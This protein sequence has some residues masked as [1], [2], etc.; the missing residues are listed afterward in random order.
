MV[1]PLLLLSR[2]VLPWPPAYAAGG[3][4]G[5][6]VIWGDSHD[7]GGP[8]HVWLDTTGGD[9]WPLDDDGLAPI[10]LPFPFTW[11]G[12]EYTQATISANGVLYFANATA[13][14]EGA[15]PSDGTLT[16]IAAY[17]DDL[18]A[19]TVHT[20]TFGV[21]PSRTFVVSWD[22]VRPKSAPGSGRVEVW[23]LEGRAEVVVVLDD[24]TFGDAAADGGVGAV[25]GVGGGVAGTG[26]ACAGGVGDGT[27]V[28]FGDQSTRPGRPVVHSDELEEPLFGTGEFLYAGRALATGDN[29]G[30]GADD[31][32]VGEPDNGSGVAYLLY[33]PYTPMGLD[34]ATTRF[35]G[36]LSGDAFGLAMAMSDLDN[37]GAAE[38][39]V[40]AP[41]SDG[42]GPA[43]GAVYT[44]SGGDR[45]GSFVGAD[46][47]WIA[48][49]PTAGRPAAG[50]SIVADADVD[51]D[52]YR[53]V[54]I[55]APTDDEG[56]VDGGSVLLLTGAATLTGTFLL[57]TP[58]A[59]FT[60]EAANERFGTALT[61]G[62]L[63]GDGRA[64][65][66]VA[67]P[68]SDAGA[69]DGGRVAVIPGGTWSG[70]SGETAVATCHWTDGV[71]GD[72]F[73]QALVVGDFDGSGF[74]DLAV[75]APNGDGTTTNVGFV[76][77][78][79][80][81]GLSGCAG[82]LTIADATVQGPSA[83]AYFGSALAV[84]DLDGDGVD[85]LLVSAP[86]AGSGAT[87]GGA[88]FGFAAPSGSLTTA[89][90][91]RQ[92]RGD[93]TAG[94][95]G[96]SLVVAHDA[97]SARDT[98][99]AGAPYASYAASS[100]GTVHAWRYLPDFLDE[101][102]DGFV[103]A[104]AGGND[105]DDQDPSAF[106]D[107]MDADDDGIDGD[108]DGWVDGVIAPREEADGWAWDLAWIGGG[109]TERYDFE[110]LA[111]DTTLSTYA[112]LSFPDLLYVTDDVYGTPSND[113]RAG[114]V[115]DSLGATMT[116]EFAEAID[117]VA[118]R[119]L[120]PEG[121]YDL[122][123]LD[124]GGAVVATYTFAADAD[125]TQGGVFEGWTFI[126][127]VHSLILTGPAGEGFGVDDIDVAWSHSSDRDGDGSTELAGDCDDDDPA[128]H[129]G[130][131]ELLDNGIDDD[132]DGIIDAGNVGVVLDPEG[133]AVVNGIVP[134]VIDFEAI[135]LGEVVDT[136]YLSLGSA[137]AGGLEGASSVG[138]AAPRGAVVARADG[139]SAVIYFR[140]NQTSVG[141]WIVGGDGDFIVDGL[142]HGDDRYVAIIQPDHTP[143]FVGLDFD[144]A[145]DELHVTP[146]DGGEV[147]GL[148]DVT[149]AL[150]GLDDADGDGT[151]EREGD[152]DDEDPTVYAGAEDEW[153]DGVDADCAG[154]NDD[155]QDG[156]GFPV[157]FDC[158]DG[159]ADVNPDAAE[160]YH[161]SIDAD[162]SG[163]SD[164]DVDGDGHDD[165]DWGGDDCDD[166][167]GEV[168]P[169][170]TEI[171][172]DGVDGDCGGDDDYDADQD[173]F[174]FNPAGGDD[175]DDA[176]ADVNPDASEVWYDGIDSDCS[177]DA[178]SD[179]DADGD[180]HIATGWGGNDCDDF[181]ATAYPDAPGERCY[182]NVDTNCDYGDDYDCDGDGYTY[183]AY[184]GEDCNDADTTIHPGVTDP[185]GDG[186]DANCDGGAEF[187]YDGDGY[188][189]IAD[190]G[191]DCDDEDGAIAPGV[192]DLCYDGIDSDCDA[193][194]DD[195]C[196]GDGWADAGHGGT[197]C[198]DLDP[199]VSPGAWDYLYDGLD[200]NCD[201][202]DDF[203]GDH[204]GQQVDWY[205][206]T[207]CDDV[208]ATVYVGAPDACYD[209]VDADC[210][211]DDD[212][213]C[214]HDSYVDLAAGGDDCDDATADVHPGATDAPDD[215]L[216]ADCD[217]VDPHVCH[218][219]D[220]DGH[221]AV[222]WGG[223]DCDDTNAAAYPGAP[224]VWYDNVDEDCVPADDFD[225]D[226]DGYAASAWGGVDC[227][228]ANPAVSP[229]VL[230]DDCGGT[231]DNCDGAVD[232][233]CEDVGD[234][235]ED[236]GDTGDSGGD[237]G[238]SGGDSAPDSGDTGDADRPPA[239]EVVTPDVKV[240]ETGGCAC[241]TGPRGGG[242]VAALG[243]VAFGL[244][245]FLVRRRRAS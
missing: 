41:G 42:N 210:A 74:L 109:E 91:D 39:L 52:G 96:T 118:L 180:G 20:R 209:G 218:D 141:F 48:R 134:Q 177:G 204:D 132:C 30:D 64:E 112:S 203:D 153:Y 227:D 35:T 208:D 7:A 19:S 202:A 181:V 171:W 107:G 122:V 104:A 37:D 217:G 163:G 197:D 29:D 59:T 13:E 230:V 158:D 18:A 130:A 116:I 170:A 172:Y 155:D 239:D 190:G 83:A 157:V 206:G 185:R 22:D 85:E 84:G 24:L 53:D 21:Y 25:I 15:C 10:D 60:G 136:Q 36:E 31:L 233:D 99:L 245:S 129:A 105:C 69:T 12:S 95:L 184:G 236:T 68:L 120:D 220:G 229:G 131:S 34:D 49:G 222:D 152:C 189:A 225:Q 211:A 186:I 9:A 115:Y 38:I 182:D 50:S 111:L 121:G 33:R 137:F 183:D 207:D 100:D 62:D 196:D 11:Y 235:A 205:G 156:D 174:P 161:D 238:D 231:D 213:D 72:H 215:G 243:G 92:L 216:D 178:L 140:E 160:V 103:S 169:D 40:G 143:F 79:T 144:V 26:Y 55:G 78:V 195:D 54:L 110:A 45:V 89:A 43:S 148:D 167:D 168:N 221:D 179:F 14:A 159:R 32:L 224:E 188:D 228:D 4:D 133:W 194:D 147:Y 191:R 51:G 2:L 192:P 176:D 149:Y 44:F 232:E 86:N 242:G 6:D 119:L 82:D 8:A 125:D 166:A 138:E 80:D 127:P 61:A 3:P 66:I 77:V 73:G 23:L 56:A 212:W 146:V 114:K 150:L 71:S 223:D 139:A 128:V 164:D 142:L 81:P 106:P 57:D 240:A 63:D 17:W 75:G 151:T 193:W 27:T 199:T 98:V 154:N 124:A 187:D 165:I 94:A 234:T 175:C 241:A 16:G 5:G 46:A 88:L 93:F 113:T 47:A 97:G 201:G 108:C 102:G 117:A 173:G 226:G 126:R 58:T 244:V 219:C 67:A 28:W 65:I 135:L 70:V 87:G 90:A 214:D 237:T 162:C 145:V 123:A 198:A 76:H 101:D 1:L 200:S